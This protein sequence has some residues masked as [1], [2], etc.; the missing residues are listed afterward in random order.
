MTAAEV[1]APRHVESPLGY[2]VPAVGSR[3]L[4]PSSLSAPT[5]LEVVVLAVG[6]AK[7]SRLPELVGAPIG[8][9]L[10]TFRSTEWMLTPSDSRLELRCGA[11]YEA[12]PTGTDLAAH[13]ATSTWHAHILEI[14]AS[15]L[16]GS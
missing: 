1:A 6:P 12:L 8:S 2:V 15:R 16:V 10:A 5:L 11:C 13:A 9:Q 14:I 3:V 7:G 4:I